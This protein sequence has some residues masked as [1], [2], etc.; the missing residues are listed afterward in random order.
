[1]RVMGVRVMVGVAGVVGRSAARLIRACSLTG[2]GGDCIF[3]WSAVGLR[4][5]VV[6]WVWRCLIVDV[7]V[8]VFGLEK[9]LVFVGGNFDPVGK[10]MCLMNRNIV[11][12]P[13]I[14][15]FPRDYRCTYSRRVRLGT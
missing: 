14:V 5:E 15:N 13:A 8:V 12:L 1:M 6:E 7:V 11:F 10:S 9:L 3:G 4:V 2:R